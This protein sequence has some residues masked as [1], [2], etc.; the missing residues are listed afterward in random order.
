MCVPRRLRSPYARMGA[1]SRTRIQRFTRPRRWARCKLASPAPSFVRNQPRC[2][3]STRA[4]GLAFHTLDLAPVHCGA[5]FIL[6]RVRPAAPRSPISPAQARGPAVISALFVP[7][8]RDANP[9]AHCHCHAEHTLIRKPPIYS[10]QHPTP[11]VRAVCA[12]MRFTSERTLLFVC[13]LR[14]SNRTTSLRHRRRAVCLGHA[15]TLRVHTSVRTCRP[16]AG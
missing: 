8:R 15:P 3:L 9:F 2:S 12:Q 14:V 6:T 11:S 1:P 5:R 4:P 16:R 10:L 13:A 7:R